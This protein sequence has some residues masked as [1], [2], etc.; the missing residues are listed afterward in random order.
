MTAGSSAVGVLVYDCVGLSVRLP[1]G[2]AIS[3][4]RARPIVLLPLKW[5]G[6]HAGYVPLVI[7]PLLSLSYPSTPFLRTLALYRSR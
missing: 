2:M 7:P 6:I 5:G 3:L 1:V 4:Y